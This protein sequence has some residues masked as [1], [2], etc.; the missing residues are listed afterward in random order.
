[1]ELEQLAG[2]AAHLL[3]ILPTGNPIHLPLISFN[4]FLGTCICKRGA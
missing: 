2:S 4:S 1:M 3:P